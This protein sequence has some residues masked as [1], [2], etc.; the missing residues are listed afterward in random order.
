MQVENDYD[1]EVYNGEIGSVED[2]DA[3]AREL[4]ARFDWS[5]GDLRFW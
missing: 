3:A 1:E 2:V 5:L 4:T